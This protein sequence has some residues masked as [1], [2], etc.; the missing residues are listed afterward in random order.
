MKEVTVKYN[1]LI[2]LAMIGYMIVSLPWMYSESERMI[3]DDLADISP[4]FATVA[5]IISFVLGIFISMLILRSLWNH[6]M[7]KLC[8]WKE[9]NLAESYALS[10][11]F[12]TLLFTAQGG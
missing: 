4:I 11:F 12:G 8:G 6:L 3:I 10:I 1:I 7:P 9:L 5:G 2:T